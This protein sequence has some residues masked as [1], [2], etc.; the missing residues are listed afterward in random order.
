MKWPLC[1]KLWIPARAGL[2]P[3]WLEWRSEFVFPKHNLVIP[4]KRRSHAARY[5]DRVTGPRLRCDNIPIN[6]RRF[7]NGNKISASRP[8]WT[9]DL[10]GRMPPRPGITLSDGGREAFHT[11]QRRARSASEAGLGTKSGSDSEDV[12]KPRLLAV[13]KIFCEKPRS[14]CED[15]YLDRRYSWPYT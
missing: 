15:F 6:K 13:R 2:R 14:G 1:F 9:P 8:A 3:A 4:G 12:P 10:G 7:D 11:P 5:P